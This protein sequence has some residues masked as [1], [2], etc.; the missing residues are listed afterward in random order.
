MLPEHREE[1]GESN[2][3]IGKQSKHTGVKGDSTFLK[4]TFICEPINHENAN[5]LCLYI[6]MSSAQT[7]HSENWLVKVLRLWKYII[8]N[9]SKFSVRIYFL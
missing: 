7:R 3:L 5:D 2:V 6:M 1:N 9:S 4:A 8:R